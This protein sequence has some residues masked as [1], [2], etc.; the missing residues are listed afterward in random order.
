MTTRPYLTPTNAALMADV[1]HGCISVWCR[2]YPGLARK[3]AGRWRID[4]AVFDRLL[5]GELIGKGANHES[6][7]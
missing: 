4:P 5:R 6:A 7:I 2:R 1:T 3:V